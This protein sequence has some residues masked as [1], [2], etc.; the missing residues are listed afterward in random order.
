MGTAKFESSGTMAVVTP[1][2]RD[3]HTKRISPETHG[4]IPVSWVNEYGLQPEDFKRLRHVCLPLRWISEHCTHFWLGRTHS[5]TFDGPQT[6]R[7]VDGPIDL[8]QHA[9]R[10][11][12]YMNRLVRLFRTSIGRKLVVAVTGVMLILFLIG[13]LLGNMTLI[14]GQDAMNAYAAWLQGHPFLWIAR[15]AL[16]LIFGAHIYAAL[17]LAIENRAARPIRFC[18]SEPIQAGV[19]SRYIVLTGLLVLAFLIY[20]LLHFT[21][22]VVDAQHA[23]LVDS[24]GRPDVYSMV[25]YGF[26]N[27]WIAFSYIVS[28]V[29]LGLHLIHGALSVFQSL[30]I[31]HE[32]YDAVIRV[33]STTLVVLLILGNISIPVIVLMG[34]IRPPGGP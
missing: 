7:E 25:V 32:T 13:H 12:R 15:A 28:M 6:G 17:W 21:F 24:Q 18:R 2:S 30:G 19:P 34:L 27:R 8:W 26:Q 16:L 20:H 1:I 4:T 11:N 10:G 29:L 23:H 9:A 3:F 14:K 31:N 33:G 5:A 22:G